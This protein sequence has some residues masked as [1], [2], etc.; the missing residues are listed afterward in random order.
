MTQIQYVQEEMRTIIRNR[1][2]SQKG[3]TRTFI[4]RGVYGN[5]NPNGEGREDEMITHW[6]GK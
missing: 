3:E 1:K 5:T 2:G 6:K 4:H